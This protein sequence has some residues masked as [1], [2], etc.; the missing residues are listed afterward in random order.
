MKHILAPLLLAL[1]FL[2]SGPAYSADF[3]TGM[4][5]AKKG[6]FQR[7]VAEWTPLAEQGD[8]YAQYYLGL[9]YQNGQGVPQDNA[10]AVKWYARAAQQGLSNAQYNLA[11]MYDNGFG[12][13][14]DYAIA[15]DWYK[16]S[17]QQG[18]ADAKYNMGKMYAKGLGVPKDAVRAYAWWESAA[19]AGHQKARKRKARLAQSM[20]AAELEAAKKL[21]AGEA[22]GL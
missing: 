22:H 16:R 11:V 7:A 14:Q 9:L 1:T 13:P 21:V 10:V 17:A 20:T 4:T 18:D 6:D 19:K 8:V 15:M 3:Q 12:V 2:T 5:A